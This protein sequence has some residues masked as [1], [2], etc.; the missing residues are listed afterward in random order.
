VVQADVASPMLTSGPLQ[1]CGA[2]TV[3]YGSVIKL[4]GHVGVRRCTALVDNGASGQ[5]F[6]DTDFATR[7]GLVVRPSSDTIQLADGT[8][9][10]AAGQALVQYSL[11]AAKG[12]PIPFTSTFTVTPLHGSFDLI[13]G[14][15]WLGRHDVSAGW[16]SRTIEVREL[17]G[18]KV[19][20]RSTGT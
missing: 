3:S 18:H 1:L 9:V 2:R 15:G 5:G 8:I 7:C 17:G 11:A 10:A 12:P 20:H 13:L 4:A 16:R 19:S 6:I 14:V